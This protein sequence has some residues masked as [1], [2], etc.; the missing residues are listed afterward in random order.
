MKLPA[1]RTHVEVDRA[2]LEWFHS[3]HGQGC[4]KNK[5]WA[6]SN[7]QDREGERGGKVT[8]SKW[9]KSARKAKIWCLNT[10]GT[11]EISL[12]TFPGRFE[13]FS[14]SFPRNFPNSW[15][16]HLEL[17]WKSSKVH[18]HRGTP[19]T[20]WEHRKSWKTGISPGKYSQGI[21]SSW[22]QIEFLVRIYL[23]SSWK[24]SQKAPR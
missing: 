10:S 21:S 12:L 3:F 17:G 14:A 18:L 4:Q 16:F 24:Q 13:M 11:S 7:H 5:I 1:N 19:C 2:P 9:Q 22:T 6:Q 8:T 15:T 20:C 23:L